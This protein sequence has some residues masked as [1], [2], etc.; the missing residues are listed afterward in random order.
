MNDIETYLSGNI[1]YGD[2]FNK[3]QIAEWFEDEKEGFADIYAN[4]E[5]TYNYG[6]HA[7]NKF[8]GFNYL[9]KQC[10]KKVLGFGS[11]F[12]EELLPIK[13]QIESAT[14]VDPSDAFVQDSVYGIPLSYVKPSP[15]GCLPFE[16]NTFD[17]MTCFGVLHH[18]PNISSVVTELA[19]ILQ[20]DGYLLIR[21]PIVSMGDWRQP[22]RGL[23]KRERGIPLAILQTIAKSNGL[24]IVKCSLCD[25]PVT[26]KVF[27]KLGIYN[28]A[29]ATLIDYWVANSFAWN[30]NY[31]PKNTLQRFRARS[32]FLVL[33]K[34][35]K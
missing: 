26:E 8:H 28:T 35:A 6:Y 20:P 17:L 16:N 7:L 22:R 13:N 9:P 1:L 14:I 30:L 21:E 27:L 15:D 32:A 18:I 31:H 3:S 2:N 4:E 11:A 24:E 29:F 10:F 34:L 33:K 5:V 25:F 12:G 19:R 23:T